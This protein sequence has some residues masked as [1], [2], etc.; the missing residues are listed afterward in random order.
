MPQTSVGDAS[1]DQ[2]ILYNTPTATYDILDNSGIGLGASTRSYVGAAGLF[3][4]T[5]GAGTSVI[6][7]SF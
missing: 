6:S 4:K 7:P 3:E 5:G 2:A 1:G